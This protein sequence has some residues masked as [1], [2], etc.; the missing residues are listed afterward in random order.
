MHNKSPYRGIDVCN[1]NNNLTK[2][3]STKFRKKVILR[4][5]NNICGTNENA[6]IDG[7]IT[8]PPLEHRITK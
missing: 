3:F 1:N 8:L 6:G 7:N 5:K 2:N 4:M